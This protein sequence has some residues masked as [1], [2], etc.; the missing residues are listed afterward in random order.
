LPKGLLE[1]EIQLNNGYK[2]SGFVYNVGKTGISYLKQ[3]AESGTISIENPDAFEMTLE[4]NP[5]IQVQKSGSS[6]FNISNK[7]P[8]ERPKNIKIK[9]KSPG[10]NRSCSLFLKPPF[11]GYFLVDEKGGL[12]DERTPLI[13]GKTK[14]YRIL[15]PF[16][17]RQGNV[18]AR[19]YNTKNINLQLFVD[20]TSGR[21]DLFRIEEEASLLFG[22]TDVMRG[23]PEVKMDIGIPH[24]DFFELKKTY[25]FRKFNAQFE[26]ADVEENDQP[27]Y[28]IRDEKK[29]YVVPFGCESEYIKPYALSFNAESYSYWIP[30]DIPDHLTDFCLMVEDD[31]IACK[32]RRLKRIKRDSRFITKRIYL[33]RNIVETIFSP[34]DIE[35]KKAEAKLRIDTIIIKLGVESIVDGEEWKITREYFEMAIKFGLP[36]STFDHLRALA[37]KPKLCAKFVLRQILFL[38]K[39]SDNHRLAKNLVDFQY[40]LGMQFLWIPIPFWVEIRNALIKELEPYGMSFEPIV[41]HLEEIMLAMYPSQ[42][43]IELV[44]WIIEQVRKAEDGNKEIPTCTHHLNTSILELR[45]NLGGGLLTE[46]PGTYP[47]IDRLQRDKFNITNQEWRLWPLLLSPFAVAL[48]ISNQHTGIWYDKADAK[49]SVLFTEKRFPEWYYAALKFFLGIN[50]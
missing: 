32:P 19:L 44:K 28:L 8:Q 25:T 29:V 9:L 40:F 10:Q 35:R 20:L 17:D 6:G 16:D 45:Q 2:I 23:M 49:R 30:D 42:D 36:F 26:I 3:E 47:S 4:E 14:G 15:T 22:L 24:P 11:K 50:K 1:Y 27:E 34:E 18:F 48:S 12:V 7:S 5:C 43:S 38:E 31:F 41:G 13:L 39:E 37:E 21:N 33:E 46:L